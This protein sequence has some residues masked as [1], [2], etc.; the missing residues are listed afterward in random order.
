MNR[1]AGF[2]PGANHQRPQLEIRIAE[3]LQGIQQRWHNTGDNHIVDVGEMQTVQTEEFM[4]DHSP[5]VGSA[6]LIRGQ[7][8][9]TD[10]LLLSKQAKDRVCVTNI[11]DE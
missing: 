2:Y 8:P 5:L 3:H 10:K 1:H 9:A 7:A 11:Y 4:D 6:R